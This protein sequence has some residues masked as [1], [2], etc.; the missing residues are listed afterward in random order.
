M[1]I[2]S[3]GASLALRS[4]IEFGFGPQPAYYSHEIALGVRLAGGFAR[5]TWDQMAV[6][7]LAA[8]LMVCMH[9]VLTR[10][11]IGRAMRAVSENP[12]TGAHQRHRRGRRYRARPG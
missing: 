11:Q 8:A 10:T 12:A 2:A 7:A 5:A 4:L 6:L 9:I 1:V 3:F